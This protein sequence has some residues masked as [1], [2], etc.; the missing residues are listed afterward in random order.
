VGP[1]GLDI[2]QRSSEGV[3]RPLN[4]G[5]I[6]LHWAIVLFVIAIVAGIL[7]FG[8][9]AGSAAVL[10]KICFFIFLVLAIASLAFGRRAI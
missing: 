10:A 5:G 1:T 8:G 2:S 4:E 7:G 9:I 3:S 6:M